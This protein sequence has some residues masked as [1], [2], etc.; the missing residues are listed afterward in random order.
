MKKRG[1]LYLAAVLFAVYVFIFPQEAN[2]HSKKSPTQKSAVQK[3]VSPQKPAIKKKSTPR[4]HAKPLSSEAELKKLLIQ[5]LSRTFPQDELQNFFSDERLQLDRNIFLPYYP[6]C[7]LADD[8]ERD[9]RGYF[10]PDCGILIRT[11]L[12]RGKKYIETHRE[13]FDAAYEKYGVEVEVVAAILRIETNFGGYTG[14]RSVFNTLYTRYILEARRRKEALIQIEYFLRITRIGEEDPFALKGSSWGAFGLPQ[15]MPYSYWHFAVDGNTD[16]V[17]DLFDPADAIA[18]AANYLREHGWSDKEK[19]R[20]NAV[21]AY[22]HDYIYVKAVLAYFN[23]LKKSRQDTE[24][25]S[26]PETQQ[27]SP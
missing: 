27:N 8:T 14:T 13:E 26:S 1:L 21:W 3:T 17:I 4:K 15:F 22:N 24:E 2:A 11:S 20:K 6:K 10:D 23:A 9:H 18:S 19:D 25:I 7:T 5:K 16:G 12:D